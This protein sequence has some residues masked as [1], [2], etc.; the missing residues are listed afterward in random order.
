M[1]TSESLPVSA[2]PESKT[3]HPKVHFQIARSLGWES[4]VGVLKYPNVEYLAFLHAWFGFWDI[5]LDSFVY[6]FVSTP[7]TYA[8]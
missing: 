5:S 3:V 7:C 4:K 2:R 1:S 6:L 8:F